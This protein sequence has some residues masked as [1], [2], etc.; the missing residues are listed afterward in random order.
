MELKNKNG[1]NVL[2]STAFAVLV[3]TIVVMVAVHILTGNFFTEYQMSTLARTVS[4]SIIVGFAQ[5]LILITGGIDLSVAAVGG[6]ASMT[7]ASMI[8]NAGLSPVLALIVPCLVGLGCG[9]ANGFLVAYTRLTPF[10]VT[11]ATGEIFQG[12]V[13]VISE[14]RP[15]L[16]IPD[17]VAEV[18][19]GMIGGVIPNVLIMMLAI[20]LL[21][22]FVLK[23]TTFGRHIYAIG[24]NRQAAQIVGVQIKKVEMWVYGLSGLLAAFA[25]VMMT[26][27]L[28]SYQA[29][30]GSTW[31][32]PSITA[33]V[34]GGTSM[35][36]G[37]GGLTGTIVGG[38]LMGVIQVSIT[39]LSVSSYWETIVIG[40]VVLLAVL[41]DAMR[42]KRAAEGM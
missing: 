27:R 6:L 37:T 4:I 31:V 34:L 7:S 17:A 26:W 19:A 42:R 10:I 32:M 28:A 25:G 2:K 20:W 5:T 14:G 21:F 13:Y 30:I 23:F 40:A 22:M 38:L 18:G 39:L 9:L 11:L 16:G 36:G 29:T 8:V 41:I 15:I 12:V 35:S 24:G 33:A 1:S 3:V